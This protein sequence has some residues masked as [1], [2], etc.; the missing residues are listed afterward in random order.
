MTLQMRYPVEF[1]GLLGLGEE[2]GV[3]FSSMNGSDSVP[4]AGPGG[5]TR[6]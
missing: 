3:G 5:S 2:S 4:P 6:F 1:L